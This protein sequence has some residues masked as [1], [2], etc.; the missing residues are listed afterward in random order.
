[1]HLIG[2]QVLAEMTYCPPERLDDL[3]GLRDLLVQAAQSAGATILGVEMHRFE[4]HGISGVVII[5]ESHLTIHTW[6]ELGYAAVDVFTCGDL[7]RPGRA[8]ELL[9]A[10]LQAGNMT[11]LSIDRGLNLHEHRPGPA[12]DA[13]A[14]PRPPAP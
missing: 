11:T 10:G 14:W 7:T 1:M 13:V 8:A 2:R 4:P 6:P 5:A 12:P 3:D 9:G